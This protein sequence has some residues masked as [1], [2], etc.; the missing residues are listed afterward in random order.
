MYFQK[1]GRNF[2]HLEK[3]FQ[4]LAATQLIVHTLSFNTKADFMY[5]RMA[6]K[7]P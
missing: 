5:L 3:F 6:L 2:E 7:L 1:P 4:K